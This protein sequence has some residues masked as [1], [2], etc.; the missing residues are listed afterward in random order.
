MFCC[1]F[2]ILSHSHS[3]GA[4]IHIHRKISENVLRRIEEKQ[5]LFRSMECHYKLDISPDEQKHLDA[6]RERMNSIKDPDVARLY[7]DA[8]SEIFEILNVFRTH[9]SPDMSIRQAFGDDLRRLSKDHMKV[10]NE[11]LPQARPIMT[12][13]YAHFMGWMNV[14]IGEL[15]SKVNDYSALYSKDDVK[16]GGL[17]SLSSSASLLSR[18]SQAETFNLEAYKSDDVIMGDEGDYDGIGDDFNV[19]H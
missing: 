11:L 4:C 7:S 15:A 3:S 19:V 9:L 14:V 8:L 18:E 17:M 1:L 5:Y 12:S 16:E 6:F 2:L 13:S 10:C